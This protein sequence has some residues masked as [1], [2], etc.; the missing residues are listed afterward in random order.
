MIGPPD[1]G[2]AWAMA[3][4]VAALLI[5]A[6]APASGQQAES[7]RVSIAA[8]LRWF[9]EVSAGRNNGVETTASGGSYQLFQSETA[10]ASAA[11]LETSLALRLSRVL[12]AEVSASY[13]SVD[14]RTQISSDVEGIPDVEASESVGQFTLE[15]AAIVAITAWR[16]PGR[17]LPYVT[18]G[19]GYLRHVHEGRT[20]A[21]TGAV[22][23]AGG[24]VDVPLGES[25]RGRIKTAGLRFD[26]RAVARKGGVQ[27]DDRMHATASLAASFVLGF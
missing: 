19:G 17:A 1:R 16:L 25:R 8:G 9:G 12:R 23:H 6:P 13:G 27:F 21:E 26:A 20:F 15:A 4:V 3:S 18:V 22:Y 24:G 14:L 5:A 2:V 7:A 11:S 10:L